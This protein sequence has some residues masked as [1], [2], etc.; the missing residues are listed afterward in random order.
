MKKLLS[1]LFCI[2]II[3]CLAS[4]QNPSGNSENTESSSTNTEPVASFD[5]VDDFKIAI[6]KN[7]K[8]YVDKYVTVK[9]YANKLLSVKVWLF[10]ELPEDDE[11]WDDRARIEVVITDNILFAVVEDKDYIEVGGTV[12]ISD[13]EIYLDNCTYTMITAYEE[14]Q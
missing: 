6:K 10:D 4:C 3:F 13:G 14:R 11:L 8:L 7:P 9:G 12:K 5:S 1:I 2:G